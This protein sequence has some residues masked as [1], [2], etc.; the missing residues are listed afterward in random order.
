MGLSFSFLDRWY[1]GTKQLARHKRAEPLLA[2][3]AFIESIFF[4]IPT[5]IMM[6]PMAQASRDKAFR[7]ATI[8]TIFSVLGGI[9]GYLLG[10][11]AYEALAEPV[12]ER[13]GK[14]H[15]M[16]KFEGMAAE[17]GALAVFGAGLTPF[18]YKVITILS[19]ALKLNF[20]VFII[21]SVLARAGQFFLLAAIVWKF[22]GGAEAYIKKHFAKLTFALFGLVTV[23]FLIWKFALGL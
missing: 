5:A 23:G 11:F 21:A 9:L 4:P 3:I 12:L 15:K 7:Y 20:L 2:F 22:G 10:M 19:G 18:P 14:A 16:E 6:L 8:C 17:Y 13:L 1:E